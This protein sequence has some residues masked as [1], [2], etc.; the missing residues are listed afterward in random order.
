MRKLKTHEILKY[1]TVISH[2]KFYSFKKYFQ[3]WNS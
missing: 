2:E 1:C 3:K